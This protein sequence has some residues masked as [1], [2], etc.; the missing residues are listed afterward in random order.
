[1]L[2]LVKKIDH[3]DADYHVTLSFEYR[4]KARFKT[5][6]D[7]GGEAGLFLTRGQVLQHGDLLQS[8]DG[9][10]VQ[11]LAAAESL[12]EVICDDALLLARLC[13]HLGNRHVALQIGRNFVR[14]QADHVLDHMVSHFGLAVT[15]IEAGFAPEI[16]AYHSH[17]D[18][19]AD[20]HS[21]AH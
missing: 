7:E 10:I 18:D 14:Y 12:S 17:S 2:K 11:V 20:H 4:Q 5:C 19:S 6:L 1:M 21:H 3:G 9:K 8:E 16:G 15:H 13:Y